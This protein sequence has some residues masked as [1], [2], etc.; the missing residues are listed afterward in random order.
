MAGGKKA[1]NTKRDYPD[2]FKHYYNGR[3]FWGKC[4]A[5][6]PSYRQKKY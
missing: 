1:F 2:L 6:S 5:K 3:A 4:Q